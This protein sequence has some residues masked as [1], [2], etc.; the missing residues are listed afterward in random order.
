MTTVA[1]IYGQDW[2]AFA[3]EMAKLGVVLDPSISPTSA[4]AIN[5]LILRRSS[6][7]YWRGKA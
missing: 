2:G 7:A 6:F 4:S 1:N 5:P 3:A